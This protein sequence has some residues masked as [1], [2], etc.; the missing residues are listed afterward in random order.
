MMPRREGPYRWRTILPVMVLVPL[1]VLSSAPS[2]LSPSHTLGIH[3]GSVLPASGFGQANITFTGNLTHDFGGGPI[4]DNRNTSAWGAGNSIVSLYAAYNQ[5]DLF[6]GVDEVITGNSLMIFVGNGGVG[7]LGTYN[8][9]GLNAWGRSITFQ[10]SIVD[11]AAVYFG[12]ANSNLSGYGTYQ[13]LTPPSDSNSTP[14]DRIVASLSEFKASQDT[15][16]IG[17]PLATIFPANPTSDENLTVSAFVVGS[18]GSWVG[19]GIPYSQTGVYNDGA[20]QSTFL[21]NDT[22]RFELKGLAVVAPEPLNVAII[23]NDHQPVYETAGQST[24][25]LPWT[26]AHATAEYIEQAVILRENPQ[27]NITYELSGSLLWQLKNISSD[28]EF[29]DTWIEGAYLPYTS[30][31][32]TQNHTLLENLT[33]HWFSIPSY[34]FDFDEPAAHLYQSLDTLWGGGGS[35]SPTEYEDAKVLWFLYEISTDLV[36]GRLG[37]SWMSPTIWALHNQSSFTQADL[38]TILTYSQ[39]LTGQVI[40]AFRDIEAGSPTGTDNTELFTSPFYHPLTPLLLAPSISGPDGSL[41]KGV[42]T[43]DVLAQMNLSRDQFDQDFGLYPSGLYASELALSEA[44]VPLINETG[45]Q[46]TLTDEWTLQQ[47]GVPAE[48]WGDS[49][50]TVAGLEDLYTPYVVDGANGTTTDVFFRDAPLSNDW[51]FNYGDLP[52]TTAISDILNYLKAIDAAIPVGDHPRTL[53]TLALDGENWQFLSPFADDGVPF[54]EGLYAALE[55]NRSFVHT[56]TPSQFLDSVRSTPW[57][58]PTLGSVATGSWNQASGS[59]APLQSN[60]SLT[61]WSGYPAQD[62]MW[63]DLDQVRQQVLTFQQKYGLTQLQ[64]LTP[65]EENLTAMTAEGNLTR[66][67]YGIYNAEG[68][69]WF[70]QMAPWTISG[71]NTVPFNLT[72]QGDLAYALS[73]LHPTAPPPPPPLHVALA[74]AVSPRE[75][76]SIEFNDTTWENGTLGHFPLGSYRAVAPACPGESFAGWST[77]GGLDVVSPSLNETAVV[78]SGNGTLAASYEAVKVPPPSPLVFEVTVM[79]DPVGCAPLDLNGTLAGNGTSFSFLAGNFT[80]VASACVG[81]GFSDWTTSSTLSVS[82]QEPTTVLWVRGNGTV[83]AVY[84]VLSPPVVQRPSNSST[85]SGLSEE[86]AILALGSLAVV[87]ILAVVIVSSRRRP[88]PGAPSTPVEVSLADHRPEEPVA[89]GEP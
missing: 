77:V 34:V 53:V 24:Y 26:E 75:C 52:T 84:S 14:S 13:I 42:Y 10:S 31:N 57:L 87:L 74:F 69:D 1:L 32:T 56:V 9:S 76:P 38:G 3:D 12:G 7:G 64:N 55:Q 30:L 82:A 73:Q 80:L 51:A 78:V 79:A 11:L 66:A 4:Y 37:A 45:S 23:F 19:A 60:P 16:E 49:S 54:L 67:W 22:L 40:P 33:S 62:W 43:S 48:A 21:V 88:P 27:V 17:I 71:A 36:E 6:V 50:P 5:T 44:M 70:F 47:S 41:S 58:L 68:S 59:A 2:G 35:L 61:Q 65:F 18:S 63:V 72:F 28:P 85:P 29:N 81:Y 89:L 25:D 46:W 39:W 15:V 83:T 86:E 20:A 8:L